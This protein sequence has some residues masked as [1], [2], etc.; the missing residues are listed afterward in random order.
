MLGDI[1][2]DIVP[3]LSSDFFELLSF[4]FYLLPHITRAVVPENTGAYFRSVSR[5]LH[6]KY[7]SPWQLH[8]RHLILFV[9]AGFLRGP[10]MVSIR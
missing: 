6:D 2:Q 9:P 7:A 10:Q 5:G 4:L 1:Y 8:Q 3:H